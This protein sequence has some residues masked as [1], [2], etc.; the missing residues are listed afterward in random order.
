MPGAGNEKQ[1]P[2]PEAQRV[3]DVECAA[4]PE[5]T[6]AVPTAPRPRRTAQFCHNRPATIGKSNSA[7]INALRRT[8][9]WAD[10]SCRRALKFLFTLAY[11]PV[12]TTF[13]I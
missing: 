10:Q 11:S 5:T 6:G 1:R 9:I 3:G 7:S 13:A 2:D 12:N 8:V 4:S